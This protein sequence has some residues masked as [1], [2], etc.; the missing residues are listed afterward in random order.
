MAR[1]F[2]GVDLN[3]NLARLVPHMEIADEY[4]GALQHLQT[5]WDN[6]ILLGQLSGVGAEM[7]GTRS[8]FSELAADLINQLGTEAFRKCCQ[9]MTSKAQVTINILVR[10]LF[11]RTADIGFLSTDDDIRTFAKNSGDSD[12]RAALQRRFEEYVRKYSVY[13]DIILLNPE[14][15]VLARLDETASVDQSADP[16]IH[17]AMTTR[18][19]YIEKFGK[20]DLIPD[21]KRSL[22]YAFRVTDTNG[23][24]LGVLCLCFRFENEAD[25]IFSNLAAEDDWSVITILDQTGVVIASSDAHHIPIGAK[26]SLQHGSECQ[27]V[28]FGAVQ[29]IATSR[30]AQPYQGYAGPPW[31]GHVMVPL[32]HA[33]NSDPSQV[34]QEIDSGV[35]SRVSGASELFTQ[36]IRNIPAKANRILRDLS[37]S[38]W[39]GSVSQGG[40]KDA[41]TT[42]FSRI[43]L[44]EISETGARTKDIFERSI[45]DLHK[46]VVTSLLRGNQFHAALAIDIMD[47]NLYER[48]NDCRWWAL[49]STI[50]ESLAREQRSDQDAEI[51]DSILR[52]I[53]GLYTVY[54]NILVFD[55]QGRIVACSNDS[56]LRGT[57]L[58]DRWISS[59]LSLRDTQ[60][61]SVSEFAPT[62]LYGDRPTYVYGA[63][64]RKSHGL[65][66]VGGVA[67]VFDSEPQFSAMLNDALPRDSD[68]NINKDSFALFVEPDGRVIACSSTRFQPGDTLSMDQAFLRL[69]PGAG[70]SGITNIDGAYYAVGVQCS[71]GYREYKDKRDGYKNPVIALV[72]TRLCDANAQ[73]SYV[74]GR[75]SVIRSDRMRAG[76]K[77][78]I[79]TFRIGQ[80]W[81]A[82]RVNEIVETI[83]DAS[84]FPLPFM[85]PMMVGCTTY[86]GSP[87]SV[88]DLRRSL[89][90]PVGVSEGRETS[91]QIVIMKKPDGTCFGLLVDDLGE[92]TEVLTDRLAQLPAMVADQQAFADSVIAPNDTDEGNL[93]VVL[94]AE[95]LHANL[96]RSAAGATSVADDT[97]STG[98][99][100][101]REPIAKTA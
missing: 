78:D 29:Y 3:A 91:N 93:I 12:A 19:A 92:I 20:S 39:N 59:V 100:P 97:A 11:E 41:Q 95:R 49:S 68:G 65:P 90:G 61:Y 71:S 32:Q 2:K 7:N 16:L 37:R 47:R 79:A 27:I 80:R 99:V 18:A 70:H 1:S 67:I 88:L 85:P 52:T 33:F 45:A 28:R 63:A 42:A 14:G 98:H 48:A 72:F 13:S 64:L 5:V 76:T 81:Y 6:L 4:G 26:L 30:A 89:G 86:K 50:S 87:L 96:T 38:V 53:N 62:A 21:Q 43:I 36:D 25:L 31:F 83:N 40:E 84:L 75:S 35:L 22:L 94:S 54:T 74:R 55:A 44:K 101:L 34:E 23:A 24:I 17:E 9:E 57:V 58:T 51:V 10:N 73:D 66:A 8:A 82:A 15:R 46:T 77:E 69:E 60:G 56:A